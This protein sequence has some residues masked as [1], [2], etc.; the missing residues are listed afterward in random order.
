VVGIFRQAT[1]VH[2]RNV[3]FMAD[4]K[5]ER[6]TAAHAETDHPGFTGAIRTRREPSSY[7][8]DV[9]EGATSSREI[10][11]HRRNHAWKLRSEV[12]QIGSDGEITGGSQPIRL[13]PQIVAHP[14][15]VVNHDYARRR[16]RAGRNGQI[17]RNRLTGSGY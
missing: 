10:I 1:V 15:N 12:E 4:R 14:E 16:T 17:R 13:P 11:S 6:K 9:F 5:Q 7:G 3:E 8:L 2:A